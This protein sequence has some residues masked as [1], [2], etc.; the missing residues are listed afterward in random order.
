MVCMVMIG[1]GIDTQSSHAAGN[2]V[3]HMV[4]AAVRASVHGGGSGD[5]RGHE[6]H[7]ERVLRDAYR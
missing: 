1:D 4:A 5:A 6:R 2:C 7:D 3:S